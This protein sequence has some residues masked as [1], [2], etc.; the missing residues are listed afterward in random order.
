[1][2][3]ESQLATLL[4]EEEENER[5]ADRVYWAPLKKELEKLHHSR[6]SQTKS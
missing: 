5:E 3:D 6:I 1:M 2:E 4:I